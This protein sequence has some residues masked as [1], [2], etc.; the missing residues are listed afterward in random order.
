[1]KDVVGVD[2][3]LDVDEAGQVGAVVGAGQST[4]AG[5]MKCWEDAVDVCARIA[6]SASDHPP[7][8]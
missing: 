7:A 2:P 4:S 3:L 5:S 6:V 8:A 1:M